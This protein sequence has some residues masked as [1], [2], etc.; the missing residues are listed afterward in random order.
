R[1]AGIDGEYRLN[2][3]VLTPL[4]ELQQ[5]HS[6]GGAIAPRTRVRGAVHKRPDRLLPL[7]ALRNVITLEVVAARQAQKLRMHRGKLFHNVDAVAV[8]PV[9]IR[10]RKE[11][12]EI[13]PN[14]CG[15]SD[16]QLEMIVGG[17]R[18]LTSLQREAVL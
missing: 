1:I 4:H 12:N 3:Q 2:L 10:R 15:M 17:S 13:E 18:D 8:G 14:G 6:V 16:G 11:R 9:M 5:A 7:V